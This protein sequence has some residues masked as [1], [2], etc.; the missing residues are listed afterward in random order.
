MKIINNNPNNFKLEHDGLYIHLR[1]NFLDA[2]YNNTHLMVTKNGTFIGS[3]SGNE[4]VFTESLYE[5]FK[6][7][8]YEMTVEL[9]DV[10]HGGIEDK[11]P[12][13]KA[14]SRTKSSD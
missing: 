14:K 9:V 8:D 13:K 2:H 5:A 11:K 1:T 7:N 6:M 12:P 10:V 4:R 3:M